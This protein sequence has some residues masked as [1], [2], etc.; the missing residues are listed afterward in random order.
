MGNQKLV[1]TELRLQTMK[2]SM[3][4]AMLMS[5]LLVGLCSALHMPAIKSS[6]R[7]ILAHKGGLRRIDEAPVADDTEG[8]QF[9]KMDGP[10]PANA[11]QGNGPKGNGPKGNGPQ[12]GQFAKMDEFP[13]ANA[14]QGNGP[15][16]NGPK[17]N[18]PQGP[19]PL[20]NEDPVA[21]DAEET[22][23]APFGA[24]EV[25]DDAPVADDAEVIDEAPVADDT[26]GGQFAK[27][28]GPAPANAPKG[29]GPKGNGPKGNGPN[30]NGP[31]GNGPKGNGPK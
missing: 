14:G 25:I 20:A 10:A 24:P 18:G 31:K 17:G 13:P 11:P 26:E 19:A 8:G 4:T 23:D 5:L 1:S 30:G 6:K 29:N 28:D 21:D 27:M 9:A 7:I 15:K 22:E 12:G 16:G 3:K 2:S